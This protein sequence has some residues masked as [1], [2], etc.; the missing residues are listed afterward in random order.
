VYYDCFKKP[1]EP[2]SRLDV[3]FLSA[4]MSSYSRCLEV[5]IAPGVQSRHEPVEIERKESEAYSLSSSFILFEAI[6]HS[7]Y[8]VVQVHG[9]ID[10]SD[11][12]CCW[13]YRR[14]RRR[15]QGKCTLYVLGR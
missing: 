1:I 13:N 9:Q 6:G 7:I 2:S 11:R 15:R 14:R 12:S 4:H 5:S 8:G 10:T 3:I